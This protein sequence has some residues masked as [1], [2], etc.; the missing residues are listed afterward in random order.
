MSKPI[1]LYIGD[2]HPMIIEGIRSLMSRRPDI[3]LLGTSTNAAH[4]IREIFALK[5]QVVLL[6]LYF[7]D[8]LGT[9][10]IQTLRAGRFEG[11]ILVYTVLP[12]SGFT[13]DLLKN[14]A[15]G[16]LNKN[17]PISEIVEAIRTVLAGGTYLSESFRIE[18]EAHLKASQGSPF[19]SL[20]RQ[21]HSVMLLLIK[22]IRNR[23]IQE[24]L[25]LRQQT[26]T[27]YTSRIFRK[28]GV[29]SL[30]ELVRAA[31]LHGIVVS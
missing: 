9:Q 17:S 5:P 27:T 7:G 11:K 16:Y 1:S 22:G 6:D 15:Q 2:D 29:S 26:V 12:E 24:Q 8:T 4:A 30:A 31:Q 18:Y 20:S 21:E 14:G 19:D 28:L 23:E 25:N 13:I 10:V 3:N